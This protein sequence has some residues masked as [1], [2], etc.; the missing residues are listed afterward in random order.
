MM[1]AT[2]KA[3]PGK[4]APQD[5]EALEARSES[6]YVGRD[7]AIQMLR[8]AASLEST[9]AAE[10]YRWMREGA[11]QARFAAQYLQK[12]AAHPELIDGFAAVLSSRLGTAGGMAPDYF[13]LPMAE[14]EA[15]EVGADGTATGSHDPDAK[16]PDAEKLAK[17]THAADSHCDADDPPVTRA[18]YRALEAAAI[19]ENTVLESGTA[20]QSA[21]VAACTTLAT[22]AAD[23]LGSLVIGDD[24]Q[25]SWQDLGTALGKLDEVRAV[26]MIAND[27]EVDDT[28]LRGAC[29]LLSLSIDYADAAWAEAKA[30]ESAQ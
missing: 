20:N 16:D 19:I 3:R 23:Y 10:P 8:E 21:A 6:F 26:L 29:A 25:P 15:G 27:D 13:D 18:W 14:F 1:S 11:A 28:R 5:I 24:P 4:Q 30:R 17:A 2:T 7:L 22:I 9:D 12:I